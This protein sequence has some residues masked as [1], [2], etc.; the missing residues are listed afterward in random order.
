MKDN[1]VTTLATIAFVVMAWVAGNITGREKCKDVKVERDTVTV[2]RTLH[3]TAFVTRPVAVASRTLQDSIHALIALSDLQRGMIDSLLGELYGE[4]PM[5]TII[6]IA[7][8]REQKEYGDTTYH[9]WVSGYQ[10]QLDSI[11]I[12]NRV[13]YHTV[14]IRETRRPSPWGLGVQVGLGLGTRDNKAFATPYIGI[15][16]TYTF[17]QF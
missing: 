4:A 1:L 5:D 16:L 2:V 12:Y 15:G 11:N 17:L 13:E 8:P 14:T 10:P 9:A 7:L 6:D 3:D